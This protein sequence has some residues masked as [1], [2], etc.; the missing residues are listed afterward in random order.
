MVLVPPRTSYSAFENSILAMGLLLSTL[1]NGFIS[2]ASCVNS[3]ISN[4][5]LSVSVSSAER[6]MAK[7][8][9]EPSKT[10]DFSPIN[11][12]DPWRHWM[13]AGEFGS[14]FSETAQV[15]MVV[16]AA[17]PGRYFCF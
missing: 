16:P 17:K 9:I 15:P 8:A 14:D 5:I 2:T 3:T 1:F 13:S 12:F 4:S 11:P 6:T 10:G 7:S